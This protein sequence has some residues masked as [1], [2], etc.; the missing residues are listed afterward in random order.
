[1]EKK[2]EL[3]G[4][5]IIL[6]ER[7]RQI[8]EEGWTPEHDD[9]HVN[10]ELQKAA[11]CYYEFAEDDNYFKSKVP[12]HWPWEPK[13]WK[14]KNQF[15]NYKRAGALYRAEMERLERKNGLYGREFTDLRI[16]LRQCEIKI[17]EILSHEAYNLDRESP[18]VTGTAE[19]A[20]EH[21]AGGLQDKERYEHI[22]GFKSG[23]EWQVKQS[24]YS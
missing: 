10:G 23:V 17:D 5:E 14:P 6:Q 8:S 24:S 9:Q 12:L 16:D 2:Q 18:P 22:E 20:T 15:E 1:M 7:Q 21:S 4:K 19:E 3:T 13:W 11:D